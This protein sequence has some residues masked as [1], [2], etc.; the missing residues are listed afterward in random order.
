MLITFGVVFV[1]SVQ[2]IDTMTKEKGTFSN[3]MTQN[4][5]NSRIEETLDAT[6][7]SHGIENLK[8]KLQLLDRQLMDEKLSFSEKKNLQESRIEIEKEIKEFEEKEE[9]RQ[10]EI[11]QAVQRRL[12]EKIKEGGCYPGSAILIDKHGRK[13]QMQSL[14]IGEEVQVISN[15]EV[16]TEPVITFIHRQP[17]VMQEFLKITTK[18]N[19]VLKITEDHLLFVEKRGQE[20]AIPARDVKVGD[21]VHLR[22][23]HG[24]EKDTVQGIS[25]VYEKGVYAPVTLSGTILVNDVHTSC[26]FDVLSHE[27]SH[28][29]MGVARA[30]HYVSPWMLQWISGV[31]QKDGFPGWCRL[32]HKMLT[33]LD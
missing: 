31:G 32:A 27:W 12:K 2:V 33:L 30:V 13:R 28:R 25:T 6:G 10:K 3:E 15:N 5:L 1:L 20:T 9:S 17:E 4:V 7:Y 11:E 29:A 23:K 19:K 24:V 16:R 18:K 21:T 8:K 26:Y 22:G 14:Q